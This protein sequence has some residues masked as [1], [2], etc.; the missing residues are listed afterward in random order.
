MISNTTAKKISNV[1]VNTKS[2]NDI[3][4][5]SKHEIKQETNIEEDIKATSFINLFI[6]TGVFSSSDHYRIWA[7]FNIFKI[8]IILI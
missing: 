8:N 3:K 4:C 6:I 5:K 2:K 1:K 7:V